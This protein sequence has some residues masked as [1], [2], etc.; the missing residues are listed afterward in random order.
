M[1]EFQQMWPGITMAQGETLTVTTNE[2]VTAPYHTGG[3]IEGKHGPELQGTYKIKDGGA[4]S[5]ICRNILSVDAS[6]LMKTEAVKADSGKPDWS[7]VPFEALEGMVRVL[8][9]GA[10][11]YSRNNWCSNGG[12]SYR[13]VLT[14]C[15]RHVFAY[16]RG[17]DNDPESG[18]SHIH[19]AQC[20]LLFIAMYLTN[21]EQFNKDDRERR[22]NVR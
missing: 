19:H 20:N 21:K 14:A 12:F 3:T 2:S 13:R 10:S 1:A 6:E 11:K 22:A 18:L 15:V 9:F 5:G 16:L 17:E 7:L 4:Y 8:E